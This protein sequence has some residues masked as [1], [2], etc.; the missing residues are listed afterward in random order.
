MEI[1]AAPQNAEMRLE[2]A[3]C[4]C[5]IGGGCASSAP[6]TH[7]ALRPAAPSADAQPW[8]VPDEWRALEPAA[9]ERWV[10]AELPD[11][12]SRPLAPESLR[13]LR[14]ALGGFDLNA[15]RAAVVLGRSRDVHSA[16]QLLA[17]LEQRALGPEVGSDAADCTAASALALWPGPAELRSVERLAALAVGPG[18]H[19]DLEVRCECAVGALDHGRDEPV[20]FLLQ[21]LRID[22]RAG[23]ADA[24][25]FASSPQTAWAR[26][27]AAEALC[28]RA[29]IPCCFQ[30]DGSI[31][32]RESEVE[33]IAA[34]LRAAGALAG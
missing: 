29:R 7:L 15:V 19:P 20:A 1:G 25:D 34:A 2:L 16:E 17:R 33:R 28:R 13:A 31:E 27:R 22:T 23:L 3:L 11:G 5:L 8:L 32:S 21:V 18:A 30:P 10:L 14:A 24:R 9:F 4:V 26:H 12:S 6:R